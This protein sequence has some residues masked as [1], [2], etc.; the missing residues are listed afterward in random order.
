MGQGYI[1][2]NIFI[3]TRINH[4]CEE[5]SHYCVSLDINF[6][7]FRTVKRYVTYFV[8]SVSTE[9]D[10]KYSFSQPFEDASLV[11]TAIDEHILF[12]TV[13][14]QITVNENLPLL[15]QPVK[16]TNSN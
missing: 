4:S 14:V 6:A 1:N 12:A 5:I 7:L 10:G 15:C 16:I 3:Q 11:F 2:V 8:W 9:H 13:T